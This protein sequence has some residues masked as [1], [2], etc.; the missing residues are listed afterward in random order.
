MKLSTWLAKSHWHMLTWLWMPTMPLCKLWGNNQ[1]VCFKMCYFRKMHKAIIH[2]LLYIFICKLHI[3]ISFACNNRWGAIVISIFPFVPVFNNMH[4]TWT[5]P[6]I[7]S[8]M[9]TFNMLHTA[10]VSVPQCLLQPLAFWAFSS[11]V[12]SHPRWVQKSMA[13]TL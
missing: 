10:M 11:V 4:W 13:V 7:L 3:F 6:V 12:R 1:Y 8:L 2:A 9:W 5:S